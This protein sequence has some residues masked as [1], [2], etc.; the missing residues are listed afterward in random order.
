M[1]LSYGP[2]AVY[3]TAAFFSHVMPVI[4]LGALRAVFGPLRRHRA[5]YDEWGQ[6]FAAMGYRFSFSAAVLDAAAAPGTPFGVAHLVV[7]V[8]L[9]D[10]LAPPD[11]NLR[12]DKDGVS[13]LSDGSHALLLCHFHHRKGRAPLDRMPNKS[14]L[15][16]PCIGVRAGSSDFSCHDALLHD[17]LLESAGYGGV[18]KNAPGLRLR[19]MPPQCFVALK[20]NEALLGPRKLFNWSA[21]ERAPAVRRACFEHV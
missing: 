19:T 8:Q 18:A 12:I 3:S 9:D 10:A 11:C 16:S 17:A 20:E 6:Y 15:S 5:N 13:H 4:N 2:I 14:V 7:P 21:V 1:Q